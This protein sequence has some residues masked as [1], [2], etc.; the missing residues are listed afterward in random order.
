MIVFFNK[1]IQWYKYKQFN[2]HDQGKN[3]KHSP[4]EQ[5]YIGL[6]HGKKTIIIYDS[7]KKITIIY[8]SPKKTKL[9]QL[10]IIKRCQ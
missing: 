2:S 9:N 10:L 6:T 3:Y 1:G 4:K 5:S 7:L 8:D